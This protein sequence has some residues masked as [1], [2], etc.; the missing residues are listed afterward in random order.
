MDKIIRINKVDKNS[1]EY[2][3]NRDNFNFD[4][5]ILAYIKNEYDFDNLSPEARGNE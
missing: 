3:V 1:R 2:K 5:S 4:T